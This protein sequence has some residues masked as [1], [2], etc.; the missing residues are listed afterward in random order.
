MLVP[1]NEV[2]L[3]FCQFDLFLNAGHG[4]LEGHS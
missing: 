4:E 3:V 2:Q 1:D